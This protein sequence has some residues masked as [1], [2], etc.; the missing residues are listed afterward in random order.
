[1]ASRIV[2][3]ISD[4]VAWN[5][6]LAHEAADIVRRVEPAVADSSGDVERAAQAAAPVLTGALRASFRRTGSGLRQRVAAG[7]GKAHYAVFQ[8][9][10]TSKMAAH[11]FLIHQANRTTHEAFARKV[12]RAVMAGQIMRGT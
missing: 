7:G 9:F 10:G 12:D 8:E 11:P 1:M 3:D 4:I 2:V 6:L 5:R